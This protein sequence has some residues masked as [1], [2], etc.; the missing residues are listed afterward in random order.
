M[1]VP[2]PDVYRGDSVPPRTSPL[3]R[4]WMDGWKAYFNGV[5]LKGNPFKSNNRKRDHRTHWKRLIASEWAWG[6][7]A[8][9]SR[10]NEIPWSSPRAGR[11]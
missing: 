3:R 10:K 7:R 9:R 4:Y 1:G 11:R 8:G 6:W 5:A 2:R